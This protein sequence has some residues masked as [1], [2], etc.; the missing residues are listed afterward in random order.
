[1]PKTLMSMSPL[2]WGLFI[3]YEKL[4]NEGADNE[5]HTWS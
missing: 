5:T 3:L 1:M 2:R 4:I